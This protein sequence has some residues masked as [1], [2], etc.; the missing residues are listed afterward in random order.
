LD[1]IT[2]VLIGGIELDWIADRKVRP[3][4]RQNTNNRIYYKEKKRNCLS[5]LL[6]S[7]GW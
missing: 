3:R 2:R 1:R 5:A 4:S 7:E 6:H